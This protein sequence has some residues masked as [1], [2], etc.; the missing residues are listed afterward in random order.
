MVFVGMALAISCSVISDTSNQ[1]MNKIQWHKIAS[2]TRSGQWFYRADING[3]NYTVLHSW[4]AGHWY[5]DD[6]R[7]GEYYNSGWS[8]PS[9][10]MKY[11]EDRF[12]SPV[13][14]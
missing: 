10:V 14:D 9:Q 4:M 2:V 8:V 3:T 5:A 1:I 11:L 7:G 13:L 6:G 12:S